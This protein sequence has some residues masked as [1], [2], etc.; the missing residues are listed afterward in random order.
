MDDLG[1]FSQKPRLSARRNLRVSE[2]LAYVG[3]VRLVVCCASVLSLVLDL[4]AV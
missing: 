4:K 2:R 3:Y 1:A